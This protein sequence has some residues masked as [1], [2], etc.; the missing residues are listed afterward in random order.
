MRKSVSL[1]IVYICLATGCATLGVVITYLV[2]FLCQ[3][4]G[5][6]ILHKNLWVLAIPVTS[7]LLLNV[8]FIE[9]Y[10]KYKKK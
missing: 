2:L 9:L 4:F 6:D 7:S 8:F 1:I 10:R 5:I 3:Y